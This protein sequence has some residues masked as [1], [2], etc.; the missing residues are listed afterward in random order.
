MLTSATVISPPWP[1]TTYPPIRMT[2]S[3]TTTADA[4]RRPATPGTA[5]TSV[6]LPVGRSR[7]KALLVIA[8][9]VFFEPMPMKERIF[10]S[11]PPW[12]MTTALLETGMGS[13]LSL[14]S[15]AAGRVTARRRKNS[16]GD[17]FLI[18]EILAAET[19]DQD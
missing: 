17:S 6:H 14:G 8:S 15:S 4:A 7:A 10:D 9:Q 18:D 2:W 1:S 5:R 11:L 19:G 3:R 12:V 16:A 13:G